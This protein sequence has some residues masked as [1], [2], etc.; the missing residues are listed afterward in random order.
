[1]AA[2]VPAMRFSCRTGVIVR[3]GTPEEAA[4]FS[5]RILAAFYR[6]RRD[7]QK[8]AAVQPM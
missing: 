6:P 8:N 5:L 4:R 1:M 3:L 7:Q 2:V